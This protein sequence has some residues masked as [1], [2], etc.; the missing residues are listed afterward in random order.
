MKILLFQMVSFIYP[1]D[2][3][4]KARLLWM[5]VLLC[6]RVQA[7]ISDSLLR[8]AHQDIDNI[9]RRCCRSDGQID[10]QKCLSHSWHDLSQK[11]FVNR[12]S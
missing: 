8:Q 1:C 7:A 11:L 2:L 3:L 9:R 5:Y 12:Q 10:R 6:N 4:V